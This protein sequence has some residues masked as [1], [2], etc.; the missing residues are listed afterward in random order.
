MPNIISDANNAVAT[1]MYHCGVSIDM[2]YGVEASSAA[3][4]DVAYALKTYFGYAS[5]LQ[6]IYKSSYTDDTQWE[7]LLK[8]ELDAGRPIQYAGTDLSAGGHSFICDGYDINDRF[9]FNWGWGGSADRLFLVNML[10][11]KTYK[12]NSNHRAIIGIQPPTG[13]Q[14][15]IM[16]L[17]NNVTPSANPINY[18][19]AFT[20]TTNIE[21]FGNN[22]F[23]GDYCAAVFDN[24]NTFIDSV[25]IKSGYS[26]AG[27][28]V[29][30]NNLVFSTSGLFSLLPGTYNVGIFYRPTGGNWIQV[31]NNG[32]YTNLVQIKVVYAN[33]IEL[34][35]SMSVTPGILTKGQPVS[36][37]LNIK[38][39][40]SATFTGD[41]MVGLYNLDGTWAQTINTYNESGGLP[42]GYTYVSPYLTFNTSAVSVNPG[43]YLLAVQHKTTSGSWNLTGSTNYPNP[44]KVIVKEAPLQ[45][46]IYEPNN[47]V[48]QSYALPVIFSGNSSTVSTT[49][50]NCHIGTDIDYYKVNLP[51]GY[52]YKISA[53]LHDSNNS[54]NGIA[55]SI[56]ALFSYTTDGSSWSDAYDDVMSG[57]ITLNNGGTVNFVVAPY[58]SGP[59]GTYLLELNITRSAIVATIANAATNLSQTSFSANWNSSAT[60]TG[61]RL[62]VAT[63]IGF[64]AFVTGY[65]DKDVSNVI[66]YSVTGLSANTPYYYRI[67]AYNTDGT[68][69]SSNII[70]VTTLSTPFLSVSASTLTIAAEANSANTLDIMSNTNWTVSSS[71]TW[72]TVSSA[73][74]N[75][76]ATI[77][78]TAQANRTLPRTAIVTVSSAGLADKTITVTQDIPTGIN[79]TE[80]GYIKSY[81]NP[82]KDF[83]TID[84]QGFNQK[85]NEIQIINIWGQQ[86]MLINSQLNNQILNVP[87]NNLPEGTYFLLFKM[88]NEIITRKIIVKK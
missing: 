44:I 29:Y 19:R 88:S 11:P 2:N 74:G 48:Q 30:S 5:T 86:L 1:L 60:T 37:N 28:N 54:G 73:G 77:T 9:N 20:I 66:T 16:K 87:I 7:N 58:F 3:T 41:Y 79:I 47:T 83:I 38:N 67:R 65:N 35:S 81:P 43:T 26:L 62:D 40:G 31:A 84:L 71:A 56:D 24:S 82:A 8:T 45:P 21:N 23:N 52:D 75:G 33:A 10:N 6:G 80:N 78:F 15:F 59:T 25:Q 17:Y 70:T 53:R 85:I 63:N 68:G 32:S 57:N 64:T 69:V 12:F 49:G 51:S 50:S 36:I 14:S 13:A 46:D 22:T 61:Y 39:T 27:G 18:S 76:N 4:L 55:Y 34:N 42:S 72:L